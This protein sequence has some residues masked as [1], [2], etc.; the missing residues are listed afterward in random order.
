MVSLGAPKSQK[1]EMD[2][3][4]LFFLIFIRILLPILWFVLVIRTLHD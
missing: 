4:D 2:L 1:K 3:S